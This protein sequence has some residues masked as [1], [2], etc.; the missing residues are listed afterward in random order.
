MPLCAQLLIL[1]FIHLWHFL[2]SLRTGRCW[3]LIIHNVVKCTKTSFL[4][5]SFKKR[6]LL[7]SLDPYYI[8]THWPF[9]VQ[10]SKYWHRP[11]K[12]PYR[13]TTT[14]YGD[15]YQSHDLVSIHLCTLGID[16]SGAWLLV[17]NLHIRLQHPKPSVA[18]THQY[19]S[20][21]RTSEGKIVLLS[22]FY[23][24][25]TRVGPGLQES[26]RSGTKR[27]VRTDEYLTPPEPCGQGV[28]WYKRVPSEPLAGLKWIRPPR[29]LTPE[30]R[31]LLWP[32]GPEGGM[33][34]REAASMLYSGKRLW[35]TLCL[36]MCWHW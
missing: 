19:W 7:S 3:Y 32:S 28:S 6:K 27:G 12:N 34:N 26:S 23:A 9:G 5:R 10:H 36:W 13:S 18:G 33:F 24:G 1:E 20:Q 25:E 2:L 14:S 29:L 17:V 35:S 22:R 31:V 21:Q 15:N 16:C 11:L 30:Q 4:I 8:Y